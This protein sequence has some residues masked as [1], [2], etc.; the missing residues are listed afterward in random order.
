MSPPRPEAARGDALGLEG[1]RTDQAPPLVIPASFFLLAPLAMFTA[2]VV[3]AAHGT[4]VLSSRW[5]PLAMAA[6]HL[7]TLGF[8]GAIMLGALYQMIPVVAGA[9]VPA[10]RLAHVVHL[11]FSLGVAALAAGLAT[12]APSLLVASAV[13]LPFALGCFVVPVAIALVRAPSRGKTIVGMRIAV[14]GLLTVATLG[15]AMALARTGHVHLSGDWIGWVSAHAAL[16]GIVWIGGLI[17]AVSWQVVPMFY[18]TPALPR[19]SQWLT[20][21]TLILALLGVPAV[22]LAGGGPHAVS[23]AVAPAAIMVWLVH[24]WVTGRAIRARRRRRIDGSVRFWWA[25]LACAPISCVL[26]IGALIGT[27]PRWAV[28]LGWTVV[29]GWAGLIAHG[30]LT[31]IVPFLVWFHRFS[32]LVGYVAVPSMRGLLPEA[33]IRVGLAL[34]VSTVVVGNVALI[35]SSPR[36]SHLAGALLATTAIALAA[37]LGHVFRQ[38][39]ARR[40][41]DVRVDAKCGTA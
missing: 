27:D 26:A 13:L 16:G 18:L 32:G 38:T 25:G 6:T 4:A 40:G 7:G 3:L 28:A 10:V 34:H 20:L 9:P 14:T 23:I 22:L 31:R 12:N 5:L 15:V 41:I 8:L 17:T 33:R 29:W 11:V 39:A 30:M 1:L 19:W 24:P 37:N 35:T 21:V 36:L 2:G